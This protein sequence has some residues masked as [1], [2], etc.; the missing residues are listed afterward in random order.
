MA[1]GLP[2]LDAYKNNA[3]NYCH[4]ANFAV[5]GATAQLVHI[6]AKKNISSPVTPSSRNV[7]LEW[8][9]KHFDWICDR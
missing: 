1:A 6:L 5:V 9:F 7:Q 4:G 8:M 3:S 2:F